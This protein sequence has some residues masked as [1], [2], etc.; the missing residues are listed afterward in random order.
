MSWSCKRHWG[1]RLLKKAKAYTIWYKRNGSTF[2]YTKRICTHL[3]KSES[4]W[5]IA[6]QQTTCSCRTPITAA[7]HQRLLCWVRGVLSGGY[8]QHPLHY[9]TSEVTEGTDAAYFLGL[10]FFLSLRFGCRPLEYIVLFQVFFLP[11]RDHS[12]YLCP[13]VLWRR[14]KQ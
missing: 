10:P 11:I 1:D 12:G 2:W 5:V 14:Y 3:E 4:Q 9:T 6:S 7:F 8:W 13:T